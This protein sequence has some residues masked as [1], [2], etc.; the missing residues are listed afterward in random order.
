MK[1]EAFL[2]INTKGEP[3]SVAFTK[4]AAIAAVGLNPGWKAVPV[5]IVER[6]S[7]KE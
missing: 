2:I 4:V 3:Q 1:I 7:G 6:R 5:L